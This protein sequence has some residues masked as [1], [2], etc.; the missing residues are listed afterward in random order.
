M[1]AKAARERLVTRISDQHFLPWRFLQ[2]LLVGLLGAQV[3][4]YPSAQELQE[5]IDS[6]QWN[7]Y[8]C[9]DVILTASSTDATVA[10]TLELDVDTGQLVSAEDFFLAVGDGRTVAT[11]YEGSGLEGLNCDATA[12]EAARIDRSMLATAGDVEL[13]VTVDANGG[14]TVAATV[15]E[16]EF[17]VS[18]ETVVLELEIPQLSLGQPGALVMH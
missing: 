7:Y 18:G 9:S 12:T 14:R 17:P 16:L 2:V 4:C 5:E 11:L 10:V 13:N 15:T 3:G 8:A 6:S 1:N